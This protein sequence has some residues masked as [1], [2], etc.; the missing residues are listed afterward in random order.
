MTVRTPV[1]PGKHSLDLLPAAGCVSGILRELICEDQVW[2]LVVPEGVH[3]GDA[4]V[5]GIESVIQQRTG[6][7]GICPAQDIIVS[8]LCEG[9]SGRVVFER[10]D[11]GRTEDEP[12]MHILLARDRKA[13]AHLTAGY[14]NA[15][16]IGVDRG[17]RRRWRRWR[18]CG[19]R[20][21]RILLLAGKKTYDEQKQAQFLIHMTY[22]R[23]Q[24][25]LID[26]VSHS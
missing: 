20:R 22:Y 23:S 17:H 15:D 14:R 10:C 13:G 5:G 7:D 24:A 16:S 18:G 1:G 2:C 8:R 19:I 4:Q 26:L 11:V 12:R 9:V 21:D 25:K 3:V 6:D